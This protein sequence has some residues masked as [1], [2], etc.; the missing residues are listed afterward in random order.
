MS[1]PMRS[2][3]PRLIGLLESFD[4]HIADIALAMREI[5]L[6]E[7][8]DAS[9]TVYE[10]SYTVAVWFGFSQKMKDMFCY[11]ASYGAHVD[12]GFPRGATLSDPNRVLEGTGKKMRHIKLRTLSDVDRP[13][14]R[15]YLRAAIEEVSS[16]GGTGKTVVKA[17][18]NALKPKRR[19]R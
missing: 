14:I 10:V 6:D 1:H 2:P 12:L 4:R 8:P 7:A 15:R 5:I 18:G 19:S 9:E 13:F 11:V 16:A 17:R 3:D